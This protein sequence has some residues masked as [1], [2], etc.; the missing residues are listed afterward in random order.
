[1]SNIVESEMITLKDQ[2][3]FILGEDHTLHVYLN[4][5]KKFDGYIIQLPP[6]QPGSYIRQGSM[7]CDI[8]TQNS[9]DEAKEWAIEFLK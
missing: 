5:S 6:R 2:Y 3:H 9:V 4:P 7:L 8:P 1:M